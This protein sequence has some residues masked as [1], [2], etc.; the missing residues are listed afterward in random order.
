MRYIQNPD[1]RKLPHAPEK[2]KL[3]KTAAF[4]L[5]LDKKNFVLAIDS[6]VIY[7]KDQCLY[8]WFGNRHLAACAV[9][10]DLQK[11]LLTP[12]SQKQECKHVFKFTRKFVAFD[13]ETTELADYLGDFSEDA[14]AEDNILTIDVNGRPIDHHGLYEMKIKNGKIEGYQETDREKIGIRY[15]D[16][17][18]VRDK[19]KKVTF[20]F[21][22]KYDKSINDPCCVV[23]FQEDP[24]LGVAMV[25]VI[26]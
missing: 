19:L 17:K 7:P 14:Y 20:E 26:Y 23:G 5:R 12:F 1:E 18:D 13:G 22:Y 9:H 15:S 6:Y 24:K 21:L 25:V 10:L 16:E 3:R 8:Y 11:V 4:D 2:A